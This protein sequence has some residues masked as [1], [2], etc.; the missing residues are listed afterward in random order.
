MRRDKLRLEK[1]SARIQD[2]CQ[3]EAA[4]SAVSQGDY[5]LTFVEA[6]EANRLMIRGD[7]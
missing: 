6:I 5:R 3:R 2:A 4:N 1:R 7:F